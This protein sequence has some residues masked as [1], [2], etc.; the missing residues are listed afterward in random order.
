MA[1]VLFSV[2]CMF[3]FL[4]FFFIFV[5]SKSTFALRCEMA[6]RRVTSMHCSLRCNKKDCI[7]AADPA[8]GTDDRGGGKRER[9]RE[10]EREKEQRQSMDELKPSKIRMEALC[11]CECVCV[12][13][14]GQFGL[15][16]QPGVKNRE[17]PS[18]EMEAAVWCTDQGTAA[19]SRSSEKERE[20]KLKTA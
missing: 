9:E 2:M 1:C 10:R 14:E 12:Y 7:A 6:C 13:S 19:K 17:I 18:E 8:G 16:N 3:I 5:Q 20:I 11:V 15:Q 4:D